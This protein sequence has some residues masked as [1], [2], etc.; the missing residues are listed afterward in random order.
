MSLCWTED[1]RLSTRVFHKRCDDGASVS[2]VTCR[3]LRRHQ[4]DASTR[5][6]RGDSAIPIPLT[7]SPSSR[8][9]SLDWTIKK[10]GESTATAESGLDRLIFCGPNRDRG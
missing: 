8:Q 4:E 5:N 1:G 7:R 2:D 10:W 3:R 6:A 9:A